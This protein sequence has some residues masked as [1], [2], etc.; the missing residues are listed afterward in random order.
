MH[1]VTFSNKNAKRLKG[2]LQ[3]AY[4][5]GNLCS[6]WRL[7]VLIMIGE[8]RD[9]E[10]IRVNWDVSVSTVYHWLKAYM[11]EGWKSLAH[12]KMPGRPSHMSKTQERQLR[13]WLEAGPEKCGYPSG[14]WTSV[15]IQD[16]IYQKFHVMYNHFYVCELLHNR[17]FSRLKA[18][19]ISDHLDEAAHQQWMKNRFPEIL[20]QARQIGT[21][22]FF[23]NEASFALWDSLSYI[24]APIGHQP[25][26]K[27]TGKRKGCK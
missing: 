10:T 11:V 24:W 7:P 9:M 25:L 23:G 20:A 8:R 13:G 12:G 21:P 1:K 19:F 4:T 27:T 22:I 26:V 5:R 16:L 15:L 14:Y 6:V 17:R 18:C 2:E 3:K